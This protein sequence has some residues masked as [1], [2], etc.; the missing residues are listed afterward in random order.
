MLTAGM[1]SA[2][3]RCPVFRGLP[4][5]QMRRILEDAGERRFARG[6]MLFHA[7][8]PVLLIYILA[9][10]RVKLTV[11]SPGGRNDLVYVAGPGEVCGWPS[12]LGSETYC[13]SACA[14]ESV[15]AL[16]WNRQYAEQ[17][18]ATTPAIS[19]NAFGMFSDRIREEHQRFTQLTSERVAQRLARALLKLSGSSRRDAE[20]T[21]LDIP[22]SRDELAQMTGTTL[23][24]VS[25]LLHSWQSEGI[26][27]PRR[28]GV[29]LDSPAALLRIAQ[30]PQAA[31]PV[32]SSA[33]S[34]SRTRPPAKS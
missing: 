30:S 20:D 4:A 3:E 6:A 13:S 12:A 14:L 28:G 27:K 31:H 22:L 15:H 25:R 17:E 5:A 7:G 1:L 2:V 32:K 24:T 8:E 19:R 9:K 11:P 33:R 26:V 16:A 21:A 29:H 23:F 10:G 18:L 34:R